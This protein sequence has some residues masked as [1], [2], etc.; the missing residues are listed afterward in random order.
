[1]KYASAFLNFLTIDQRKLFHTF[2][3]ILPSELTTTCVHIILYKYSQLVFIFS[4][5]ISTVIQTLKLLQHF[6]RKLQ[7]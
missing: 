2:V 6:N 7:I 5:H 4:L 3:S 1:M